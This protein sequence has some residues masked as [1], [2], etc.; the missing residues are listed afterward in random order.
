MPP[1]AHSKKKKIMS[2]IK[3]YNYLAGF[4]S[5]TTTNPRES[6][7]HED[8]VEEPPN[9]QDILG[10]EEDILSMAALQEEDA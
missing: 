10:V 7:L 1:E 3:L 5:G 6:L 4:L 8:E 2:P 9:I